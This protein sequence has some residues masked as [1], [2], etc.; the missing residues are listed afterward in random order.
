ML[1][2]QV[3][4][5]SEGQLAASGSAA[6]A[7]HR[8]ASGDGLKSVQRGRNWVSYR[9]VALFNAADLEGEALEVLI[10]KRYQ[11]EG[12]CCG[13]SRRGWRLQRPCSA[14]GKCR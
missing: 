3:H 11:A 9:P 7:G 2:P 12:G 13:L 5:L 10:Q 4:Q 14:A 6:E 1:R 8:S